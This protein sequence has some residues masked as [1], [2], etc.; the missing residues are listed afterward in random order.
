[1]AIVQAGGQLVIII[2]IQSSVRVCWRILALRL[3]LQ[4]LLLLLVLLRHLEVVG[5]IGVASA[6]V[7]VMDVVLMGV[8]GMRNQHFAGRVCGMENMNGEKS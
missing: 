7:E 3:N 1:M 4:L 5:A 2:H 8:M 6:A